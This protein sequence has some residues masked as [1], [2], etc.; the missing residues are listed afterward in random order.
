MNNI[1]H[2]IEPIQNVE[3]YLANLRY[4]L[5]HNAYIELQLER[6]VDANRNPEFT[7]SYTLQDL[8][9]NENPITAI[10]RE[11]YTLSLKNYSSTC[12]DIRFPAKGN[13]W[14]FGKEYSGKDVYIKIR[15]NLLDEFGCPKVFTMSFHYA[16]TTIN[17]PYKG[18]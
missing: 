4:A 2:W 16:E 10:R 12:K 13:M 5:D 15:V 7:N 6:R 8:F 3:S 11:L 14:E 18:V 17:F 1:E 9:A